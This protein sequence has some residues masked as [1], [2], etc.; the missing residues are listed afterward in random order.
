MV[1]LSFTGMGCQIWIQVHKWMHGLLTHYGQMFRPWHITTMS[2]LM[3]N[4]KASLKPE[5]LCHN[6]AM[7]TCSVI[8]QTVL[9]ASHVRRFSSVATLGCHGCWFARFEGCHV[10]IKE[11]LQTV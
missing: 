10:M 1:H 8:Y 2:K 7:N 5:R 4:T 11:I 3:E 6:C 9:E